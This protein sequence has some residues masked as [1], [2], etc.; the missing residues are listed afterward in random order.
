LNFSEEYHTKITM[1][2][3]RH[4]TKITKAHKDHKGK[5][6]KGCKKAMLVNFTIK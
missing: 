1:V 4:L 3:R 6:K 5:N 2:L